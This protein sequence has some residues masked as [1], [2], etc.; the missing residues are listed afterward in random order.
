VGGRRRVRAEIVLVVVG[1]AFLT[2]AVL[3]PW[4]SPPGPSLSPTASGAAVVQPGASGAEPGATTPPAGAAP[5]D[6]PDEP[7]YW[8]LVDWSALAVAD[9]HSSWGAATATMPERVH[10]P[11]DVRRPA[12]VIRWHA[13]DSD[14]STATIQLEPNVQLF[15]VAITW[16]G[17]VAVQDVAFT[18]DG[19]SS[20]FSGGDNRSFPPLT[21]LT[22]TPAVEVAA[23]PSTAPD[24]SAAPESGQ[25]W[26]APRD[27][28]RTP[29]LCS[30]ASLWKTLP[31]TWPLGE[32]KVTL[33]ASGST[34]TM[35]LLLEPLDQ[36]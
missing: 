23:T 26:I 35:I 33:R 29:C 13:T 17:G 3:K 15:A 22:P 24:G 5:T 14:T 1:L 16:P 30:S 6:G 10:G 32:Y 7:V 2:G 8:S 27:E 21:T 36:S 19:S 12:P 34:H 20:P 11:Q 9:P 28:S 18:Y 25:F 4:A 31:W